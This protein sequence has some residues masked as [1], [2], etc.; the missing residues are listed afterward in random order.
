MSSI[1]IRGI[2]EKAL[3][4]L[5]RRAEGAAWDSKDARSL[6]IELSAPAGA[7]AWMEIDSLRFY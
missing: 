2:D 3:A 6:L 4:R 1:S 5:K 7:N